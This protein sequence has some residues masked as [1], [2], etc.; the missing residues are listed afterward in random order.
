MQMLPTKSALRA[1]FQRKC[2]GCR[3]GHVFPSSVYSWN[4]LKVNSSCPHCKVNFEREPG[5]FWGALFINYGFV[6]GLV[7]IQLGVAW[8][9]DAIRSPHIFWIIPIVIFLF[10]PLIFQY[11]RI[12]YLYLVGGIKF[13]K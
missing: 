8:W 11:S 2:P 6:T 4:F 9:M 1:I 10:T 12:I 5:F 7:L 3:N 13:E